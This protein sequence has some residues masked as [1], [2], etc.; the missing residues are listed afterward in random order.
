MIFQNNQKGF[1]LVESLIGIG[2]FVMLTC[3]VY[4]V[5]TLIYKEAELNWDNTTVSFLASQYL[6]NARNIPYSEIG[7]IEGNPHGNLP[8]LPNPS[9]TTVG[10]IIYQAYFEISYVDD[11]ADGTILLGNDFASNDYKQV[12]LT[13]KNTAT[14][15]TSDFVTN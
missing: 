3:V 8:D 1:T 13:I 15:T 9:N 11:S 2:I 7:T 12:K 10:G 4:Q 14:N 6:E 5:I